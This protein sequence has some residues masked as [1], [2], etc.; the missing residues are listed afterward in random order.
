MMS[1]LLLLAGKL[2][3]ACGHLS[4]GSHSE[5]NAKV[6]ALIALSSQ[7]GKCQPQVHAMTLPQV[8]QCAPTLS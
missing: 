3:H 4:E 8:L 7:R 5:W 2:A 1:C 6:D